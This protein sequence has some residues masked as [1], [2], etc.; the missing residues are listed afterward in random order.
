MTWRELTIG[1]VVGL[2]LASVLLAWVEFVY[3]IGA[4]R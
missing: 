4:M 3:Q 1:V 2:V